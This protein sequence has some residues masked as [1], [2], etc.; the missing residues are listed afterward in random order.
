PDAFSGTAIFLPVE[1]ETLDSFEVGIKSDWN[2]TLRLNAAAFFNKYEGLQLGATVP[3]LGFTR[4]NVDETEISGIEV[5]GVWQVSDNF[6][7]NGNLGLLN[8]EY[9]S[10]TGDQARGVT[11]NGAGCPAGVDPTDDSA[12]I[13]CAL[14]LDLKS[15][16]EYKAT[17]GALYTQPVYQGELIISADASFEDD[18]WSLVANSP[19]HAFIE[20]DT[21]VNAREVCR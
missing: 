13:S 6:Q 10:L 8:A 17:L 12:I 15:A 9:T 14:G 16:P 7:I 19:P 20:I 1:E 18:S 21:L 2:D 5:E 4:F 11:N 3:G